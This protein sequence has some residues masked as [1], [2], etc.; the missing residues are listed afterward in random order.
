MKKRKINRSNLH[1]GEAIH[2]RLRKSM[3]ERFREEAERHQMALSSYVRLYL[4]FVTQKHGYVDIDF[5]EQRT[6]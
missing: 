4:E 5:K 6:A 2:T 1:L 3:E